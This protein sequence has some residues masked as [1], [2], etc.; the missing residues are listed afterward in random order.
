MANRV[1]VHGLQVAE[2]LHRFI[3]DEAL[4]GTGV[5]PEAFWDGFAALLADLMPRNAALLD[6]RERLQQQIDAWHQKRRGQ[7]HDAAAYRAFLEEIGYLVPEGLTSRSTP[8]TSTPRSRA[9]PGRSSSCRSP[10]PATR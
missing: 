6:T 10:M 1:E 4:P 3:V 5:A 9:S 8:T 2:E 7:P